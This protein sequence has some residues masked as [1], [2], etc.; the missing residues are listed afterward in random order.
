MTPCAGAGNERLL[1]HYV[2]GHRN[3]RGTKIMY[4][5]RAR[6]GYCSPPFV[7]EDFCYEF[8]KMA[9]RGVTLMVTTLSIKAHGVTVATDDVRSTK[10]Q[11]DESH[12]KSLEAAKYMARSGADVV[13]LGGNPVNQSRGVENLDAICADLSREVG[14]KVITSTHSQI[15]ALKALGALRVATVH[16]YTAV[17]HEEHERSMRNMGFLS[18]GV[19]GCGFTVMDLGRIPGELALTLARQV[20]QANPDTDTIHPSCAHWATAHAIDQIES[21][22]MVNVMTS[23]QAIFWNAIRTAGINDRVEGYGRLLREF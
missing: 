18:S 22:L 9:P 20:K 23:Q 13:V 11:I 10:E 4:G 12:A 14:T 15:K 2:M 21:E 17:R 16:P 7:T 6:I 8:Y 19:I 1:S 5:Y 3:L